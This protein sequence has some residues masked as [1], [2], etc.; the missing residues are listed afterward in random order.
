MSI[1][2][3]IK[4]Q[5]QCYKS[6]MAFSQLPRDQKRIVFYC[7]G[8]SYWVHL[9][10]L[11]HHWL[12]TSDIPIC[13][14]T[15]SANDPGLQIEHPNY[16]KFLI[17]EGGVRNWFF[18]NIE[19]DLFVMTMPDIHQ[20]QVKRSKHPVHYVYVQH[21]IVSLQMIYRE[22][23]FDHYDTIFCAGPHHKKEMRALEKQRNLEPKNLVEHGY[24]RLESILLNNKEVSAPASSNQKKILI[25]PSWG[26]NSIIETIGLELVTHLR[27][28]NYHVTLRPH[29]QTVKFDKKKIDAIETAFKHDPDFNLEVD[30]SG[31]QSLQ[32]ASLMICD[33]SGAALDFAFGLS[34]PVLFID[35][36]RKINNPSYTEIPLEPF[37]VSIRTQI[38]DIV[39][40]DNISA[41]HTA[42]QAIH[43]RSDQTEHLNSLRET[44]IY[45]PDTAS[46]AG[47]EALRKLLNT[48]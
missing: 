37:E 5:L 20:Y 17:D 31:Q 33:W 7:E 40:P 8:K 6:L 23:A 26:E 2:S 39:S 46:A 25:A 13:F 4:N 43:A 48:L 1:F 35:V 28:H 12:E 9:S 32:D 38:G 47:C 21:S 11:I 22:G 27:E 30:I 19:T 42:I 18:E 45:N 14:V 15:S 24:G 16:H 34:K 10:G 36:A 41:V 29:P 3:T 44:L